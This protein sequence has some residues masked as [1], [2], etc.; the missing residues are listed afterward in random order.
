MNFDEAKSFIGDDSP[1]NIL[2]VGRN[3]SKA[4]IKNTYQ[5][6][7]FR[8]HPNRYQGT[9]AKN[10]ATLMFKRILAAYTVLTE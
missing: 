4:E 2:G 3:A 7:V 6:L 9:E 5:K 8:W 1:Y 10:K